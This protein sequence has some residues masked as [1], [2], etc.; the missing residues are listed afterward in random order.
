MRIY[1]EMKAQAFALDTDS[2][3]AL[4]K[5]VRFLG[6]GME[7]A[8]EHVAHVVSDVLQ[9]WGITV[10][11]RSHT[12]WA[13]AANIFAVALCSTVPGSSS[14]LYCIK[15]AFLD[16]VRWSQGDSNTRHSPEKMRAMLRRAKAINLEDPAKI[17]TNELDAAKLRIILYDKKQ[18]R[19][20]QTGP[21]QSGSHTRSGIGLLTPGGS[22]DMGPTSDEEVILYDES[23]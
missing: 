15:L 6:F 4:A 16:G 23:D 19:L 12:E 2:T 3:I 7:S 9:G 10:T 5:F 14:T 8:V 21:T 13:Q 17:L 1:A 11:P 18:Q 22:D 20:L